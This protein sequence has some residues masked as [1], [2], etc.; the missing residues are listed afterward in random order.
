M[1]FYFGKISTSTDKAAIQ[2]SVTFSVQSCAATRKQQE[3][4][5]FL[6]ED[7]GVGKIGS[8]PTID[9]STGH[10]VNT[11]PQMIIHECDEHSFF[12]MQK[13]LIGDAEC[14][15]FFD[16]VSNAHLLDGS[17]AI[18]QGLEIMSIKPINIAVVGG[19]QI[20][21]EYGSF[22]FNLGPNE[23]GVFIEMTCFGVTR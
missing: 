7:V 14:L 4:R 3:S 20:R 8:T 13:I 16:S 17:V 22:R 11:D 10:R 5:C 9:S 6:E 19:S 12:M 2:I 15:V 21:T 18:K 23:D 1:E